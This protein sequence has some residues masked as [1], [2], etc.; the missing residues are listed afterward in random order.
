M[1][2]MYNQFWNRALMACQL[3]G[4][5]QF[6][7]RLGYGLDD[8]RNVVRFPACF[9]S[10]PKSRDRPWVPSSIVFDEQQK[11]LVNWPGYKN[12]H[13]PLPSFEVKKEWSYTS[14]PSWCAHELY[15]YMGLTPC[16]LVGGTSVWEQPTA[17]IRS[18]S[19]E[20]NLGVKLDHIPHTLKTEAAWYSETSVL[21]DRYTGCSNT[22]NY[23]P[24]D[25]RHKNLKL[26]KS[27]DKYQISTFLGGGG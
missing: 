21:T 12:D 4:I 22:Q 15:C 25:P 9:V 7:Q 13:S 17:F 27:Y 18:P 8:R 11:L 19:D 3:A 23:S 14:T 24:E 16:S 20:G 26:L 5:A 1:L 6:L 2:E 10:P